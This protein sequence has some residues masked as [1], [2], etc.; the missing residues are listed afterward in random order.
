MLQ[1]TTAALMDRT[2]MDAMAQWFEIAALSAAD[3]SVGVSGSH[4][5]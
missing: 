2:E 3:P 5:R 1:A 4:F